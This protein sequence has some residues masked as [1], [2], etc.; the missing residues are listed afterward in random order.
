LDFT[1]PKEVFSSSLIEGIPTCNT[2]LAITPQSTFR[3][4]ARSFLKVFFKN[5]L[6]SLRK[7]IPGGFVI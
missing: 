1:N 2:G 5:A 3:I 4:E 7:E 6:R